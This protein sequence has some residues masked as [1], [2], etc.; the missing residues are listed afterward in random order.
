MARVTVEDCLEQVESRFDLVLKAAQRARD[1]IS[2]SAEPLVEPE[3]DK[4]TIIALR[5]IAEGLLDE[6]YTSPSDTDEVFLDNVEE[7]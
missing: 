2:T 3:N 6:D 5:E 7:E 4:P 1:L